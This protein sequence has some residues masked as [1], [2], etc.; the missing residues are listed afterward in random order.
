MRIAVCELD[1]GN[2]TPRV[3]ALIKK[4]SRG[5]RRGYVVNIDETTESIREAVAEAE[6][7]VKQRLRNVF[8]AVGGA[9]LSSRL[10]D[11]QVIVSRAD[12]EITDH[13]V[14][15]VI[16]ASEA[17]LTDLANKK[18]LHTIPLFYKLDGQ[19][20]IGRPEGLKG[21]KLEVKTL[22]ITC[23]IQHLNNLIRAAEAAGLVVDDIVAAP[24]AASLVALT[25]AQKAAGVVLTNIGAQTTSII[26]FEEGLPLSLQ[27]F[28]IGSTDITNDIA[29][30]LRVPIEEAEKIKLGQDGG[31]VLKKKL[32]EIV[33]ARLSDMF[34]LIDNH[35]KKMGRAGLL[36]AGIVLTGGG[37]QIE[38]ID[39]LARANLRLPARILT[40]EATATTRPPKDSAWLV[41]YGLTMFG[42]NLDP[43]ESYGLKLIS[44][45]KHKF[46][47]WLRELWP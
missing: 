26:V 3:L 14:A 41:A 6:R 13:D 38:G 35:L 17:N 20:I 40:T 4:E 28:P 24:L 16:E 22:F 33:E 8:L 15:R 19:K 1:A 36:P 46:F 27:V 2:K 34:E 25:P 9:P 31:L 32:E 37:G 18:I 47:R 30:G 7:T 42:Y 29:L 45:G 43:E 5:L 21:N 11:G 44:R 12:S 39:K 23:L 10:S